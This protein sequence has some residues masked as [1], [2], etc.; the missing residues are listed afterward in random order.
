MPTQQ[1]QTGQ[2]GHNN[3][4]VPIASVTDPHAVH[5]KSAVVADKDIFCAGC[6]AITPHKMSRIQ[7][8]NG[9]HE[10]VATC[11]CGRALKFPITD[12]PAAFAAHLDAH[13]KSNAGQVTVEKAAA[14]AAA[15]DERFKKMLG[16]A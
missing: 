8:R 1:N 12:D 16:I 2:G 7:D 6:Q 5:A 11:A 15:H 9:H 3:T 14:D 4:P 13:H 10:V